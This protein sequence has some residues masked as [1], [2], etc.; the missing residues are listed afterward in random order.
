MSSIRVILTAI[1][2]SV[3]FIVGLYGLFKLIFEWKELKEGSWFVY[4]LEVL[5]WVTV[6]VAKLSRYIGGLFD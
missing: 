5:A 6:I 4:S 2:I 1:L 3:G